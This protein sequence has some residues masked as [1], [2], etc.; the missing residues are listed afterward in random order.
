MNDLA[1]TVNDDD[2]A[3]IAAYF[4]SRPKMKGG[5][6]NN[7]VGKKLFLHGDISRTVVAC[8]NC[9]G[10]NGK[11]LE[12]NSSMFPVIGGQNK[13]YLSRQLV[14][15]RKGDRTNSPNNIM[16]RITHKLT[17]DELEALAEYISGQ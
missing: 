8:V 5:G 3:D 14:N 15:F 4:A 12:P 16:N 10:K 13:D 17:D 11:G 7:K 9:H 2:L 6:S 1:M